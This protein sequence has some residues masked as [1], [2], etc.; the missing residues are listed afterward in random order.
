MTEGCSQRVGDRNESGAVAIMVAVLAVVLLSVAA[1][2]VDLGNAMNRKQLTQNSADFSAL[3]GAN[4]LPVTD[5]TT[6]Q[7]VADYLNQ[8]QPSSDG[9][10]TECNPDAGKTIT[11]AMLTDTMDYNGDVEFI[12][13]TRI[14]VL[15]PATRV[16]FG[17]ANVMGFDDTCVQSVAVARIATGLL[18][19][20]PYY[21]TDACDQGPQVLKSD[22]GG[23]S[24][25]FT[26][27]PLAAGTDTNSSVLSDVDPNPNPTSIAL[28]TTGQPDG[29]QITLTGINLGEATVDLVGFFSSN[30]TAPATKKPT[31]QSGTS[32]T[33]DVP[34]AVASYQDVW[35]IR[36]HDKNTDKWSTRSEARPLMVGEVTLS[37]DPESTSGNFGSIEFPWSSNPND[38]IVTGIRDGLPPP[39]TLMPWPTTPLPA[40]NTCDKDPLGVISEVGS[41]KENTNC[42]STTTG[43]R[44]TAAY[45]GLLAPPD[46]RLL[47]PTS[48][49]C[50]GLGQPASGTFNE[51]V[52]LLSCFLKNDGDYLSKAVS[53]SGSDELFTQ[54]IWASPRFMLIPKVEIDPSGTKWMPISGFV[55]AFISDEVTGSSK[56]SPFMSGD[57]DNGL[58][59]EKKQVRAMR[60]FFFDID[61][62]P[63]PPDGIDLQDYIGSGKKV[64]TLID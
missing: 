12:G 35:W 41:L 38:N 37:C 24:I 40:P 48:S 1:L 31:A 55:P 39:M 27:P 26:V 43:L 14:R 63:P 19:M 42:L 58:V 54:D 57:T 60:V 20:A 21:A 6:V 33:V 61:A 30:Q 29:P 15:A 56:G 62:L 64:V 28:V 25:P 4:G 7:K 46:G 10:A 36:V 2:G 59:V 44:A 50:Q 52:D 47:V 45:D 22:A 9:A 8:N 49:V 13:T 17:M 32:L 51:N 23:P 18:G 53:Y 34:N 5:L 16:Q 11:S 3:A